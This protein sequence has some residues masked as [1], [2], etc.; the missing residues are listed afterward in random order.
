MV[1]V[2]KPSRQGCCEQ[3]SQEQKINKN[4]KFIDSVSCQSRRRNYNYYTTA[5]LC[6]M[7]RQAVNSTPRFR[8]RSHAV[9]KY[10]NYTHP[11][12]CCRKQMTQGT[13]LYTRRSP[14]ADH[15][16]RYVRV[17]SPL[18]LRRSGARRKPANDDMAR[19]KIITL[20]RWERDDNRH[21]C[22]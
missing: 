13:Y 4:Q 18:S 8:T 11:L 1:T 21:R 17:S 9:R 20:H 12:Y 2:S 16:R 19:A 3:M 14:A 6:Q 22:N 10:Y 5:E 7:D 15:R